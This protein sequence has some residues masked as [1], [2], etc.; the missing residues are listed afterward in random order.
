[1]HSQINLSLY[2]NGQEVDRE[3]TI[4]AIERHILED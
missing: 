4:V 1:M 2:E 3:N